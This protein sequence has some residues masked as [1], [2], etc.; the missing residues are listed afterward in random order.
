MESELDP[1]NRIKSEFIPHVVI[2]YFRFFEFKA[3]IYKRK[4]EEIL[5]SHMTKT[6]TTTD[7]SKTQRDKTKTPS[8]TSITQ[9][10]G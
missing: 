2:F 5:L 9:R 4:K 1:D 6:P 7:T 8:K 10:L 3:L